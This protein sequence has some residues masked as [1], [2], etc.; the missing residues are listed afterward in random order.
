MSNFVSVVDP[1][2]YADTILPTGM[3]LMNLSVCIALY[4]Y[5]KKY[6]IYT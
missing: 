3:S 1:L 6:I 5:N 2:A 4:I